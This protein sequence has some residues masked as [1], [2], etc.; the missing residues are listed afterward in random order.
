MV[1]TTAPP[2][3][4]LVNFITASINSH[5]CNRLIK[6]TAYICRSVVKLDKMMNPQ[7]EE[8]EEQSKS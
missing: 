1:L 4:Y 6:L 8:E 5:R 3:V 7:E 2:F